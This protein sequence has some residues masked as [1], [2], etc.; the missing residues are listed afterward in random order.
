[1]RI[2]PSSALMLRGHAVE[3]SSRRNKPS[4]RSGFAQSLRMHGMNLG[5]L[6]QRACRREWVRKRQ[7]DSEACD[8]LLRR[9]ADE[10]LG[11][12]REAGDA[13]TR[14][15]LL[16]PPPMTAERSRSQQTGPTSVRRG[17]C[18][19]HHTPLRF[20]VLRLLVLRLRVRVGSFD[21]VHRKAQDILRRAS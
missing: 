19:Y 6:R 12:L 20:W 4:L 17:M 18:P 2:V 9:V 14:I 1:M 15:Y 11:V 13:A 5:I 3:A 10:D 7:F 8:C 21:R 16:Y